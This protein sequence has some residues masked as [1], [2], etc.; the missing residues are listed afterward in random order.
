M[1]FCS[2]YLF[3]SNLLLGN[4]EFRC[5]V[6]RSDII[7]AW[8][9]AVIA[10]AAIVTVLLVGIAHVPLAIVGGVMVFGA[11]L[12]KSYV[13]AESLSFFAKAISINNVTFETSVSMSDLYFLQ[14]KHLGLLCLTLGMSWPWA[15]V[16]FWRYRVESIRGIV[17][18]PFQGFNQ[19]PG[20]KV[21]S[22]GD[23][24]WDYFDWDLGF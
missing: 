21:S 13:E 9:V 17:S 24:L 1:N 15:R 16:A 6:K 14:T 2:K 7:L 22:A 4:L 8:A 20:S 11:I 5:K 10:Y 12:A 18:G 19:M 23:A 3:W